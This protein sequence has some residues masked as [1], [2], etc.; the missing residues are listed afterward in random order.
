MDMAVANLLKRKMRFYRGDG[1]PD[2]LYFQYNG[3]RL[4]GTIDDIKNVESIGV[5]DINEFRLKCVEPFVIHIISTVIKEERYY[6]NEFH[7]KAT[8]KEAKTYHPHDLV[9]YSLHNPKE[10]FRLFSS[11][12]KISTYRVSERV[13]KEP[14]FLTVDLNYIISGWIESS[15]SE[16]ETRVGKTY[17][18]D[19][20]VVCLEAKPNILYLD[21]K[22]IAICDSCDRLKKTGRNNCDVCRAE[23]SERVK[24]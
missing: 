6:I 20:C 10:N 17:R 22:H 16:E 24:I 8:I 9:K 1:V 3:W 23:I 5:T 14:L 19:H 11:K 18:E 21:C 13:I 7:V 4:Y 12:C 2:G 15:L